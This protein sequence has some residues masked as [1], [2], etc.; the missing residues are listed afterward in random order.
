MNYCHCYREQ[1]CS[2]QFVRGSWCECSFIC[3]RLN[4]AN[5]PNLL[6]H[7]IFL[8]IPASYT[9]ICSC[10]APIVPSMVGNSLKWIP[11][12][13]RIKTLKQSNHVFHGEFQSWRCKIFFCMTLLLCSAPVSYTHLQ[14][15][16]MTLKVIPVPTG[17]HERSVQGCCFV[18]FQLVTVILIHPMRGLFQGNKL[19]LRQQLRLISRVKSSKQASKQTKYLHP[20]CVDWLNPRFFSQAPGFSFSDLH[21]CPFLV[22]FCPEATAVLLYHC[23]I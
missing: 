13:T 14:L 17:R 7:I 5:K 10:C 18:I 19:H 1:F 11:G 3:C 12:I 4:K 8:E 20:D 22:E 15:S 21:W 16:A 9:V 2:L 23:L 6:F